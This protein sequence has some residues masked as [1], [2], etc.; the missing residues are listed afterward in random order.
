MKFSVVAFVLFITIVGAVPSEYVPFEPD[1][2]KRCLI[3]PAPSDECCWELKDW[4]TPG[5]NDEV[6]K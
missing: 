2:G 4:D 6:E 5:C 3:C 1:F